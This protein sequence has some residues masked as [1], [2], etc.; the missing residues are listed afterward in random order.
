M[1]GIV[2][3]TY[4]WLIAEKSFKI[5]HQGLYSFIRSSGFV[6]ANR[7]LNYNLTFMIYDALKFYQN[8]YG[9]TLES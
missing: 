1:T 7:I 2:S 4:N 8:K 9:K 5:F 3:Q 6:M